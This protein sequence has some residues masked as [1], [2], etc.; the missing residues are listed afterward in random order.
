MAFLQ[1]GV[2]FAVGKMPKIIKPQAHAVIDYVVAGT[3]FAV[4]ALYWNRN[5]RAAVSSLICGG[6]ATVNSVLTDYPGGIWKVMSYQ[7]HGKMDAGLAG[8]TAAMPGLM[9]F[10]DDDESRFFTAQALAETT[11]TAM[12][13]FDYYEHGVSWRLKREEEEEGVA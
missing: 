11:V 2:E 7:T 1:K 12:T 6:V 4:A 8:M 10:K 9:G 13:D 3:F 5:K